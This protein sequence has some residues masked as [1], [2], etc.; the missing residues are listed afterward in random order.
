MKRHHYPLFSYLTLSFLYSNQNMENQHKNK[1]IFFCSFQMVQLYKPKT[2]NLQEFLQK[3]RLTFY[4]QPPKI[5]SFPI[6]S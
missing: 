2:S 5:T 6:L 1:K 4:D 3:R